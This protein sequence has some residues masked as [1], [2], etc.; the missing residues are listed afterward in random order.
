MAEQTRK[1]VKAP[2]PVP[3]ELA[4][5]LEKSKVAKANF[6]AF[7]PS[8]R[9]E[10]IQWIVSAK[11]PETRDRRIQSALEMMVSNRRMNDTYR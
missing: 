4:A 1:T 7:P 5:A 3:P 10:Y 2:L 8:C 9:R 6:D 11:R